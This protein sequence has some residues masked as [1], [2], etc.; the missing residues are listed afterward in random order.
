[1]LNGEKPELIKTKASINN[2]FTRVILNVT[3][4]AHLTKV[5]KN[6]FTKMKSQT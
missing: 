6:N 1:M 3:M 5:L 2:K 4:I